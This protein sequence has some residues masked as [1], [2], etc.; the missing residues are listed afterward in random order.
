MTELDE[1]N[2]DELRQRA[3]A[4][5][6]ARVIIA[7][8]AHLTLRRAETVLTDLIYDARSR[9][10][11]SGLNVAGLASKVSRTMR[12]RHTHPRARKEWAQGVAHQL[13]GDTLA[14]M[15]PHP[16]RL[17]APAHAERL[18]R[19]TVRLE[20]LSRANGEPIWLYHTAGSARS[21]LGSNQPVLVTSYAEHVAFWMT[22]HDAPQAIQELA[23]GLKDLARRTTDDEAIVQLLEQLPEDLEEILWESCAHG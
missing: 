14:L 13:L 16:P 4:G 3:Y 21:C 20:E 12:A 18:E 8:F 5:K 9:P 1:I 7:G 2:F 22:V 19:L 11:L 10:Y 23:D 6:I 17:T 15:H